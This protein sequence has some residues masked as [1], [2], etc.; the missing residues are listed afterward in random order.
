MP[1]G[2]SALIV[3][4]EFLIALDLQRMLEGLGFLDLRICRHPTEA[5]RQATGWTGVGLAVIE[6]RHHSGDALH[7]V[8]MLRQHRVPTIAITSDTEVLRGIDG[9]AD[10]PVNGKPVSEDQLAAAIHRILG[11]PA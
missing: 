5:L 11:T 7:L 2:K 8:G 6:V 3:E 10:I 9:L 1:A 4:A